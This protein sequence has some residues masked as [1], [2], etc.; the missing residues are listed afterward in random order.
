[1]EFK[2]HIAYNNNFTFIIDE[3]FPNVGAAIY[4]CENY[5]V[6]KDYFQKSV[7]ICKEQAFEEYGVPIEDWEELNDFSNYPWLK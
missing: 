6:I 5:K 7:Q 4:I 1:M 3:D 2:K